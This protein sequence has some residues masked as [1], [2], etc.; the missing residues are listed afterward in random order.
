MPLDTEFHGDLPECLRP[1]SSRRD[2]FQAP[3][4]HPV[5]PAPRAHRATGE[6]Q[7]LA[8]S[9]PPAGCGTGTQ[10]GSKRSGIAGRPCNS[11]RHPKRPGCR[12]PGRRPPRRGRTPDA[13]GAGYPSRFRPPH[14]IRASESARG[15]R[16]N[17]ENI[18]KARGRS[19]EN[20]R[21]ELRKLL[22]KYGLAS[23]PAP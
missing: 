6:S 18:L 2:F 19:E 8:R 11:G 23:E 16:D 21:A 9:G 10:A 7:A 14:R 20:P 13:P 17:R 4:R 5:R 3:A 12:A 22:E 1:H 15:V